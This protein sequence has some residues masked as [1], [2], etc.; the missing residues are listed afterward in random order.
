M[1]AVRSLMESKF[2]FAQSF[3]RSMRSLAAF[4][5]LE[6]LEERLLSWRVTLVLALSM[7]PSRPSTWLPRV[8]SL[9]QTSLRVSSP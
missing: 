2:P 1:R 7:V 6:A 5:A 3:A 9:S 4:W 8:S